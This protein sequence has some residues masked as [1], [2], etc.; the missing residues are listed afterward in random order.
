M[1]SS[2]LL[3]PLDDDEV[4]VVS[5]ALVDAAFEELSPALL[6]ESP[7]LSMPVHARVA[8]A[9]TA[10]TADRGLADTSPCSHALE[11]LATERLEGSCGRVGRPR[12]S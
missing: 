11:L 3:V 2:P 10:T 9:M 8:T 7:R 12:A 4:I 5:A 1:V 6:D